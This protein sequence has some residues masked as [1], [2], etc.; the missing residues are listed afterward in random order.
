MYLLNSTTREESETQVY[1][2]FRCRNW[3]I[4]SGGEAYSGSHGRV[5]VVTHGIKTPLNEIRQQNGLLYERM[6]E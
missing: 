1:I 4:C 3:Y 2:L 5:A 6:R